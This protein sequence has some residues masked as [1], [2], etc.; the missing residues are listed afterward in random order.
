[1]GEPADCGFLKDNNQRVVRDDV[2][3]WHWP[4]FDVDPD[5]MDLAAGAAPGSSAMTTGLE[6]VIEGRLFGDVGLPLA[7]V[8]LYHVL[9]AVDTLGT[10]L[11]GDGFA[12]H[13]SSFTRLTMTKKSARECRSLQSLLSFDVTPGYGAVHQFSIDHDVHAIQMGITKG[14]IIP[15]CHL[16]GFGFNFW[17]VVRRIVSRP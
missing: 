16:D 14:R 4:H 6:L 3:S 12:M 17:V 10:F 11:A 1:L 2:V 8:P 13:R 5:G 7:G 15:L 9:D